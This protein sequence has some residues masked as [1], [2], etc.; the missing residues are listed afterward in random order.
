VR[1]IYIPRIVAMTLTKPT[2]GCFTL[3]PKV[4]RPS[5]S[6]NQIARNHEFSLLTFH[7]GAKAVALQNAYMATLLDQGVSLSKESLGRTGMETETMV[8][9]P[10]ISFHKK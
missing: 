6:T 9:R 10:S 8:E 4:E 5:I 7:I 3:W 2:Q 1:P